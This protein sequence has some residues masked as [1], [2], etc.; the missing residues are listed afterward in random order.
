MQ[1]QSLIDSIVALLPERPTSTELNFNIQ[2]RENKPV[3]ACIGDSPK[4]TT[5]FGNVTKEIYFGFHQAGFIVHAFGFLDS[6]LDEKNELPYTFWPCTPFDELGHSTISLFI[7]KV[8]PDILFILCDPGNLAVFIDIIIETQKMFEL[9]FPVVAYQPIE[10][11]PIS[12][13]FGEAFKKVQDTGGKVVAYSPEMAKLIN[14]QYPEIKPEFVY[15]GADHAPFKKYDAPYRKHLRNISGLDNYFIVG[16]VG[17][18]KRTKGFDT[19]I[20]TARV[21]KDMGK[22]QGIKFYLHTAPTN[23]VMYGYNLDDLRRK[24]NVEDMILFKP[25]VDR[26]PG[27]NVRGISRLGG[28]FWHLY[29]PETSEER[30][31]IFSMFSFIDRLNTLDLYV[32]ASQVEG[33]GLPPFEAMACGVPT[34]S[35][36]DYTIRSEIFNSGAYMLEP[37]P[38]RLWTTWHTGAKLVLVDPEQIA[39]SILLFKDNQDLRELYS[40]R[41]QDL[42]SKF[43]WGE[44]RKKMTG[45]IKDVLNVKV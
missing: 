38:P 24:Y 6:E 19:L 39:K 36:H 16:S 41:G 31:R 42:T 2:D 25:E 32:D 17:T 4:I 22:D 11:L 29:R 44:S 7:N 28:T 35:V 40:Q 14:I 33:W 26:E 30:K 21:L 43:S 37:E 23:P 15:H 18:N 34:I 9:K 10:N 1:V 13:T 8:K 5:G 45:I 12:E 27:G 20:Y 3:I